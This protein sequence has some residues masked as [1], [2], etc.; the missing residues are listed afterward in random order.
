VSAREGLGRV[1]YAGSNT[2]RGKSYHSF[3][4]YDGPSHRGSVQPRVELI[5]GAMGKPLRRHGLD[6]GCSI[7]GFCLCLAHRGAI[8][9][10]ID[11]DHQAIAVATEYAD[12]LELPCEFHCLD[13]TLDVIRKAV[14]GQDIV[15]WLSQWMWFVKQHGL[16]DG[17]DA[18]FEIG[19]RPTTLFFSTSFG[20]GQAGDAMRLHGIT[21]ERMQTILSD[22]FE[23]VRRLGTADNWKYRPIYRCRGSRRWE[24]VGQG[25]NEIRRRGYD[26][27]EKRQPAENV[28][29]E[30]RALGILCSPHFPRL[31]SA[32]GTMV[33]MT[34]CGNRLRAATMPQDWRQQA[35]EILHALRAAGLEHRDIQPRNLL[36]RQ[37]V[38]GLCDFSWSGPVGEDLAKMPGGLNR[39]HRPPEG[40][41]DDR[42]SLYTS[43][44]ALGAK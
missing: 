28:E 10:G 21:E 15:I 25:N 22:C 13:I 32:H 33:E 40:G 11:Y 18:L 6:L 31:L 19:K 7:G 23:H 14:V 42:Y 20:D 8:M 2:A 37:G 43:L 12:N 36:V 17:L 34:Y 27:I 41:V 26:R 1:R 44:T 24:Y 5:L 39:L 4:G 9:T 3:D 38:I 29:R 16:E 35:E 30:A